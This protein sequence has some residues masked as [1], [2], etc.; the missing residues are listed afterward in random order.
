MGTSRDDN[1]F[2][3]Q[4]FDFPLCGSQAFCRTNLDFRPIGG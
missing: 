3:K 2:G 4:G 1:A